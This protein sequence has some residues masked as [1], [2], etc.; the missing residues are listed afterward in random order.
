MTLH[1]RDHALLDEPRP[2]RSLLAQPG[3]VEQLQL[4]SSVG[5]MAIHGG[6]LEE[7]TD[8]VA[9]EAAERSGASYYAVVQP[10]EDQWHIP[11]HLIGRDPS[12]RLETF[13][14]HVEVV[15][16]L[17]GFGRPELWRS[18]LLGGRNRQVAEMVA[19]ELIPRLRHYEIITELKGIPKALR[20][21]HRLNPVNLPRMGGVQIELPPRVRG[22]SPIF[23]GQLEPG[24][25]V[26]HL[27]ALVEGLAA[28][29]QRWSLGDARLKAP[30]A[31]LSSRRQSA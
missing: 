28:F 14:E 16:S 29:A 8:W 24:T 20:G 5:F 21:Q 11:S 15:V 6:H 17:H 1:L 9:R 25:I 18:L 7:M 12:P 10:P 22:R 19:I 26:P 30:D 13:L 3:V 23:W 31:S 2:F 4:R 27:E